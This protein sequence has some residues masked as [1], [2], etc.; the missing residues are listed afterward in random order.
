MATTHNKEAIAEQIIVTE[1]N[2]IRSDPSI[3]KENGCASCYV[4]FKLSNIM[5]I[6][7]Q[8]ASDLLSEVLFKNP[9][10]NESFIEMV[11]DIHMKQR[12]MGVSF[13][14]KKRE[15]K[16]KY[17]DSNFKNVLAELSADLANYGADIVLRKLLISS[18]SLEIAKNIG[19]D[20]HAAIEELYYYMRKNDY[21]THENMLEFINRFYERIRRTKY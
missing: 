7:E 13:S 2:N 3:I 8:D 20:H 17:I 15:A 14:I 12:M 9:Q 21:E 6:S 19:I 4:L 16:I 10:I 1:I 5:Q 11:E 18:I